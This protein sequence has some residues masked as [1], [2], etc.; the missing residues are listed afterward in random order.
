MHQSSFICAQNDTF[1]D[2]THSSSKILTLPHNISVL[3]TLCSG[4]VT[5]VFPTSPGRLVIQQ[6][7]QKHKAPPRLPSI[8]HYIYKVIGIQKRFKTVVA[9]GALLRLGCS[10]C[11][12][13][14]I[15]IR[16]RN[17]KLLYMY[18]RSAQKSWNTPNVFTFC[19][20][21]KPWM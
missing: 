8:L 18:Y 11:L 1:S 5:E 2:Y 6:K 7:W 19:K 3:K 12:L 14:L 16:N 21:I 15:H 10:L 9:T 17:R 20:K 4:H 13:A